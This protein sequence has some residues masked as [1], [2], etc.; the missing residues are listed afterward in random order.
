MPS[1][2]G[3]STTERGECLKRRL[4]V[5]TFQRHLR[6]KGQLLTGTISVVGVVIVGGVTRG[7][8]VILE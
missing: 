2:L 3:E 1:N 8:A 7:A 4:R 6:A 5:R